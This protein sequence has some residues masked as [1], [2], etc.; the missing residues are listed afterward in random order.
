MTYVILEATKNAALP[1]P[2][3]HVRIHRKSPPRL[4][5]EIA[6]TVASGAN[7]IAMFSDDVIVRSWQRQRVPLEEAR[8]YSTVGCVELAPFGTS[9]TSS[10]AAL[11]NLAMCLELA[12]NNGESVQ[13]GTKFG[14]E[15][16]D[17]S[18]FQSMDE[19]VEAFRKQ[20][21]YLV[22]L[23]AEGSNSFETANMEL[24]P[25]PLLSLCV[26]DCFEE[27]RDIT[28]G[29]ARYNFTGV[30]GVGMADVADSLAAMDR[31]VFAQ[32]RASMSELLDALRHGFEGKE[33]LRQLLLNKGPKYGNDDKLADKYA[34]LVARIY[35]EEV[36]KHKNIRGG[37]FIAGMYSVTSHVPFGYFTGAL[38]SGRLATAP[39]SN[40]CSPAIGAPS[41]GLT[42]ALSSVASI[43]Y[44]TYANGVAFTLSLEP[45]FV[46]GGQGLDSLVNLLRSYVE[47]G[48][49]HIQF[50]MMD[51]QILRDA[52]TNPSEYRNLL[53]RVAGYSACFVDL[54]QDVQNDVIG[55][56]QRSC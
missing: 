55:R 4:L 43:D 13:L 16:G 12:L 1:I 8:D 49:M 45:G 20:V 36:E 14:V 5:K 11:F 18:R 26:E 41:K 29:S 53:V 54:S 10:D 17:P 25:S 39:L 56:F 9:F 47:L 3:V 52:Q 32:K 24:M 6:S 28:T 30:Q 23:M 19:I 50:N 42:A 38:P 40:G 33:P 2:N 48:G 22:G 7:N 27:G 31:L 15:T 44:A 51:P 34:Q 46:S 37:S 21:S 35:S